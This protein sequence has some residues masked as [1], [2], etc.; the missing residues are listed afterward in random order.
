MPDVV[1]V[2]ALEPVAMFE[3]SVAAEVFGMDRRDDGGPA[4]EFRVCGLDASPITASPC[5]AVVPTH[6]R[7]GLD[8]ADLVIVPNWYA[9]T[10]IA[11]PAD[12]VD[13]LRDAH[14]RGA[15]VMS[16]CS[17]AFALA[18]TGLLDGRRVATHWKYERTLASRHPGVRVDPNVLYV[19][20]DPI[21]TSAGTAAAI[22]LCL[23][24]VRKDHGAK[25]ANVIAR[26]MIVPPHR[27]GGQA[28]Y[29]EAVAADG[30]DTTLDATMAWMLRRIDHDLTVERMARRA[31]QSPRTFAR[32]F[33]ALTGTTPLQW[34]LVQRVREAQ[35][36][37]ET[38]DRSVDDIASRCGLG[39]AANLRLHFARVV[40]TTPTAYRQ[41]F[42]GAA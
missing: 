7:S 35:R 21:F 17:G 41:M 24:V 1:A 2:L 16:F 9:R 12:A 8:G 11:P 30:D 32:R 36:L 34:L 18:A 6:D 27:E 26:R 15:R 29:I 39:S 5:G 40:G 19:D 4:F 31:K 22:D 10:A 20:D 28:Q 38:T 14:A 3:L 42:R 37:L 33:R 13:A 23:H 25:A